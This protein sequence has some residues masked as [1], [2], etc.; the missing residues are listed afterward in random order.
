MYYINEKLF[1]QPFCP[2]LL[3]KNQFTNK[4]ENIIQSQSYNILK[5][6]K[7]KR[8]KQVQSLKIE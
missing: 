1:G 2:F 5:G 3:H 6:Q 4:F 7:L 8:N